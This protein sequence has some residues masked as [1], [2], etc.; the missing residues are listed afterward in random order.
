MARSIESLERRRAAYRLHRLC[1]LESERERIRNYHRT[2]RVQACAYAQRY[3]Q[4]KPLQVKRAVRNWKVRNPHKVAV[5]FHKRRANQ[6]GTFTVLDIQELFEKQNG[7]CANRHWVCIADLLIED[8]HIDH[9]IPLSR[10]GANTKDNLQLLCSS[11]NLS[12]GNRLP[13]ECGY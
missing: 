1:N 2:N 11:C 5:L 6:R 9:I 7:W 4:E 3:R 13:S 8:F 10:G 12:K